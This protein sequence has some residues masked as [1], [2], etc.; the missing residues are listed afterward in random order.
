[1][2]DERYLS[3]RR[4]SWHMVWRH[5]LP[6]AIRGPTGTATIRHVIFFEGAEEVATE[7]VCP[8]KFVRVDMTP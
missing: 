4:W 6:A 2:K 1:M 8:C 5:L 3:A 7:Y